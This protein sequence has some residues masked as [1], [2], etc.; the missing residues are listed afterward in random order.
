VEPVKKAEKQSER[1]ISGSSTEGE[2]LGIEAY[3]GM[4]LSLIE[5]RPVSRE[6][7]QGLIERIMRQHSMAH[8]VGMD[9]VSGE[10]QKSPP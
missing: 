1:T 2:R 8:R 5:G 9:Y 10:L 7:V 3:L 4:V 6:E